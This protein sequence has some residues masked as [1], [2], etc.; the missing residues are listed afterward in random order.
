MKFVE[1]NEKEFLIFAKSHPLFTFYHLTGWGKLKEING[2]KCHFMGFK[3]NG[4]IIAEAMLLE[5]RIFAKKSIFYCP[6]GFLIDYNNYI[7]LKEFTAEIKKYIKNNNGIMLKIDPNIIYQL[8]DKNGNPKGSKNDAA[9]EQLKKLGFKH[10]GFN[11]EFETLQPRFM[12]RIKLED[13][14][15]DTLQTFTKATKKRIC[16]LDS[17]GV[18]TKKATKDEIPIAVSMLNKTAHRKKIATRPVL[19]YKK[20]KEHLGENMDFFL[21]YI[22]KKQAMKKCDELLEQE[23]E[24]KRKIE[25]KKKTSIVGK[26]IIQQEE[27]NEKRKELLKERQEFI[28]NLNN[29]KTY[30]GALLSMWVGDEAITLLS[31]TDNKY[32]KFLPKYSF[33]DA[34]IKESIKKKKKYVNFF[35]ISGIFD[36]NDINYC[37]YEIKKGFNPEIIELIGEFDLV[38]NKIWY[39]IY[40]ITFKMYKKLKKII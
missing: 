25:Q 15:E 31:G 17:L 12:C 9:V 19:Y 3:D 8:R 20:M 1:L 28:R 6:K 2:W 39:I 26:K 35:G 38:I 34:H 30:I 7:L 4:K 22:D 37:I 27:N 40:S 32:K 29:D 5:K 13:N 10:L 33:Y 21:C 11:N 36:S 24:I 16:E 23:K 18:I 14:Y